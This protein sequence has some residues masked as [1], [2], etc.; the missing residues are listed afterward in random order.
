M[1]LEIATVWR[2]SKCRGKKSDKHGGILSFSPSLY[3]KTDARTEAF[4]H[5]SLSLGCGILFFLFFFFSFFGRC[6]LVFWFIW[7]L[8]LSYLFSR[9]GFYLGSDMFF[10]FPLR[11]WALAIVKYGSFC[12]FG[13]LFLICIAFLR[14]PSPL[15]CKNT[16]YML[17]YAVHIQYL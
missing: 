10:W 3:L 14:T 5:L 16:Q 6:F 8:T 17:A 9:F 11:V 7:V 2:H 12:C 13:V 1:Q 4:G 15:F